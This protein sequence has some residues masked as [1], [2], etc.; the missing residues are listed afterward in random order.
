[1]VIER[2]TAE[3]GLPTEYV[4]KLAV[5]ASHRY[6]TYFIPKKNGGLR[7]IDHPARE[8]KLLQRWILDRIFST[9]TVSP[10]AY[11]YRK[12]VSVANHAAV[13]A[14]NNFLLKID[15][16]DFFPSIHSYDVE[17]TLR[18][19]G[20]DFPDRKLSEEDIAFIKQV[21][22]KNGRLTIG[23]PTSPSISNIVMKEFD[24]HWSNRSTEMGITYTRYA[25]DLCFSC[26]VPGILKEVF[27]QLKQ[28]LNEMQSPRLT[29][30]ETKTVFTS[31]KRRRNVT[32]IVLTSDNKLSLGRATKRRIRSMV[33]LFSKQESEKEQIQYLQGFLAYAN[34]VEPGF[35]DSLRRKFGRAIL[36]QLGV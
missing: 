20:N 6:K 7:Q 18:R 10:A 23:A 35:V 13:H 22:C 11:G 32:G 24:G 5:S 31:R 12:G 3:T 26:S 16:R 33:F 21:V 14:Q 4:T 1:M 27:F 29:L 15:F 8:L 25:D 19:H 34:S 28:H 30:N 17:L 9:M 36:D 2:L